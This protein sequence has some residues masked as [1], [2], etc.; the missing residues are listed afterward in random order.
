MAVTKKMVSKIEDQLQTI[1]DTLREYQEQKQEVLANAEDTESPNEERV[2]LLEDQCGF[3]ER[4]AD[5]VEEALTEL[6]EYE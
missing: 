6:I 2:A 5:L 1:L 4:A 3:L